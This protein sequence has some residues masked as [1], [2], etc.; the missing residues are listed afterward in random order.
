MHDQRSNTA[1]VCDRQATLEPA[2]AAAGQ[3]PAI[4][5]LSNATASQA[6]Q[7]PILHWAY[8]WPA[9]LVAH[10]PAVGLTRA[11]GATSFEYQY[12][13]DMTAQPTLA[14]ISVLAS[15]SRLRSS[16]ARTTSAL[17]TCGVVAAD[18]IT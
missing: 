14:W 3:A 18:C 17:F 6:T 10:N 4:G 5:A 2:S 16:R 1:Q 11:Q 13:Q 7:R 9:A 15:C 8:L 12:N